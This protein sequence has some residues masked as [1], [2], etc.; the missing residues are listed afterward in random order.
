M[1]YRN[2]LVFWW[3]YFNTRPF[4]EH[5]DS[6]ADV[7]AYGKQR[8]TLGFN[9]ECIRAYILWRVHQHFQCTS[10]V[11]TGTLY[12]RT[13][14]YVRKAFQTPVFTSEINRTYHIVSRA[15]LLWGT[16][17]TQYRAN[18]PDFLR[19][20]CNTPEIG[21]N[22]M[23]YLDA[24]WYDYVPLPEELGVIR[25]SHDKAVIVI[26]DFYIPWEPSFR[27]DDYPTLRIDLDAVNSAL[28]SRKQEVSVYLPGY[29]PDLDPKGRSIGFA[30]VLMGQGLQLP[31]EKFPFDLLTKVPD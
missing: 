22:P 6:L 2:T 23:F 31:A 9:R 19:E 17:I 20:V 15:N 10:F 1:R 30:V 29:K 28:K 14:G 5:I 4:P 27:Y 25:D 21:D 12:G 18:S 3:R 7:V 11:E 26:D 24:H 8:Y 16:K 13:T